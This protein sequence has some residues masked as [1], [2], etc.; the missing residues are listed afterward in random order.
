MGLSQQGGIKLAVPHIDAEIFV[1][2]PAIERIL[3]RGHEAQ[4]GFEMV[5]EA[6]DQFALSIVHC[7]RP[8]MC[9]CCCLY[10]WCR[11]DSENCRRHLN[12]VTGSRVDVYALLQRAY[13]WCLRPILWLRNVEN[14]GACWYV[15]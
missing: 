7:S 14:N 12:F 10:R 8:A 9:L 11:N 4:D 13:S 15:H 5:L 2:G 6:V 1:L 3:V